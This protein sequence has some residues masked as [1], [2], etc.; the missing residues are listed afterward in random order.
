MAGVVPGTG[1][2][3][4]SDRIARGL[5][6]APARYPPQVGGDGRESCRGRRRA[7]L[8]GHC[9]GAN[10]RSV[11]SHALSTDDQVIA[12]TAALPSV[13]VVMAGR[14]VGAPSCHLDWALFPASR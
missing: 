4:F 13:S 7:I 3:R 14:A 5:R 12:G 10:V 11:A 9:F 8:I 1:T 2:C 6:P